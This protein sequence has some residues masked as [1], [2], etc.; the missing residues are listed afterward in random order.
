MNTY[1][2]PS[3][4][5]SV[6]SRPTLKPGNKKIPDAQTLQEIP[7]ESCKAYPIRIFEGLNIAPRIAVAD[8]NSR[9]DDAKLMIT[10]NPGGCKTA[11]HPQVGFVVKGPYHMEQI[12]YPNS[13]P[14]S[15]NSWV[16]SYIDARQLTQIIEA[17]IRAKIRK[18][19]T[20][21]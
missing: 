1:A 11:Q 2:L 5:N 14:F 12:A 13:N 16:E 21:C 9:N 10:W 17:L 20:S 18:E 15:W 4:E 19:G 7:L 8:R 6:G 3:T